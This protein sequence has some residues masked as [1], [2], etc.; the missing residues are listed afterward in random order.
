MIYDRGQ[1]GR[2]V[3][4]CRWFNGRCRRTTPVMRQ[5][6]TTVSLYLLGLVIPP[7]SA[8]EI[9]V[10]LS[11]SVQPYH[12]ALAGFKETAGHPVV[13]VYDMN[14]D[15]ER[16][17]RAVHE[18]QTD[19][20]PDLLLAIGPWALR[21]VSAEESDIPV[22]F[23][24]VLNPWTLLGEDARNI[25]GASMNV[26]I[27]QQVRLLKQLGLRIRRVGVVY[28]PANTG[29]L[30][31]QADAIAREEGLQ[32]MAKAV[33]AP[34]EAIAAVNRLEAENVDALWILP[35]ETVLDPNIVQYMLLASYRSRVPLL[36]LSDRQA[37]MGALLSLSFGSSAD[38]GRQAGELANAVLGG[39][40]AA[41]VPCV[42]ARSLKLTVNL[43]AAQKLGVE[44]PESVLAAADM[45][46][47]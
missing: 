7:A 40:P 35:D 13:A 29:P 23:T 24:M 38:I 28:N 41:Q 18:I 45:I 19:V 37:E 44:V 21:A 36:G 16:G 12:E 4:R 34:K 39:K 42:P 43:R 25:T 10:I 46:I 5:T 8:A 15:I 22:V 3:L 33:R 47:R 11:A 30:I 1:A 26:S 14:A 2:C 17:L 9:A 20:R 31:E 27:D 32:L 6:V